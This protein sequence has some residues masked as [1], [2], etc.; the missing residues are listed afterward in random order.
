MGKLL[1]SVLLPTYKRPDMLR[2]T[3][4]SLLVQTYLQTYQGDDF[5]LI[6]SNDCSKDSTATVISEYKSKFKNFRSFEHETNLGGA[7]NWEFLLKQ[8]E[9]EFVYLLS[10]DDAVA[11][12]F[13]EEYIRRIRE[14]PDLDLIF[15]GLQLRDS[16]FEFIADLQVSQIHGET[17]GVTRLKDQL[18]AHHMVISACYRRLTF[19]QAGGWDPS[20]GMH[21]DCTAFCRMAFRSRKAVYIPK[22]LLYYRIAPGS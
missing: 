7:K 1:L 16:K 8:A 19:S 12:S 3:F 18:L 14:I 13:L 22:P 6:V 20:V 17:D 4:D 2:Q 10:D 5:E 15:C 21:L 11:P 9:G